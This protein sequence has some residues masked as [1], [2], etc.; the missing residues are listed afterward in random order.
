MPIHISWYDEQKTI[1]LEVFEGKW[2]VEDY[3]RLIDDAAA[4]LATVPHTVHIMIDAA[5]SALPPS[6]MMGGMRYAIRK[7]PLNQGITVFVQPGSLARALIE[8]GK[9]F[10]PATTADVL[11]AAS[12]EEALAL[13]VR[14]STDTGRT[15]QT[16]GA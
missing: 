11:I 14:H 5:K 2:S 3:Y 12:R 8:L 7:R 4:H 15:T 6:A 16:G 9:R 10:S 1:L 13:I